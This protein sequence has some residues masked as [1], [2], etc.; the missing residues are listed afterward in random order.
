[1]NP[2]EWAQK[3]HAMNDILATEEC[4][5]VAVSE[6]TERLLAELARLQQERDAAYNALED[7]AGTAVKQK[8]KL[9]YRWV[10]KRSRKG[11]GVAEART[12]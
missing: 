3:I 7:I 4:V 6:K 2:G 5:R 12:P 1:M 8:E 11:V 10:L 9:N